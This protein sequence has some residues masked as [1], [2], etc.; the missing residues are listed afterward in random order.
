MKYS[1]HPL[2]ETYIEILTSKNDFDL[3]IVG[4]DPY[5]SSPIGIPFCKGTWVE[6]LQYNC[7]GSHVLA[8]IGVD[9]V[10]A[11]EKYTTPDKLFEALAKEG[12]GFLNASYHFLDSDKILKKHHC[13]IEEALILNKPIVE[14]SKACILCGQAKIINKYISGRAYVFEVI[15]PD[16]QTKRLYKKQWNE[17]WL[18]NILKSTFNLSLS[19]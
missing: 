2:P 10:A 3:I 19:I 16:V 14:K 17:T 4:K 6:L 9:L 5:P 12:I 1:Y 11:K 13:Y 8:S 15:H 7:S 18:P